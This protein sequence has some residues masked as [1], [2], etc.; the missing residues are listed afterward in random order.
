ML[1]FFLGFQLLMTILQSKLRN[2]VQKKGKQLGIVASTVIP[3]QSDSNILPKL[4]GLN[5]NI[6]WN[7]TLNPDGVKNVGHPDLIRN[8]GRHG[9]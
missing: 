5:P 4:T 2:K 3:L 7:Q 8:N 6:V 1:K 9:F